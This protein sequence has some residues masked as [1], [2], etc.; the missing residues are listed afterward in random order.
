MPNK[1]NKQKKATTTSKK[2]QPTPG[3]KKQVVGKSNVL[4]AEARKYAKLINDP[5]YGPI[6]AP[7]YQSSGSGQFVRIESDFIL[8]AEATSVGAACI[9]TPG[10]V[11]VNGDGLIKPNAVVASD[12]AAITWAQ[13]T[14]A[15]CGTTFALTAGAVRAVSACLQVSFV[16]SELSRAGVVSLAQMSRQVAVTYTSLAKLRGGADRVVRMPDGVLEL[17][18]S[19]QAKNADFQTTGTAN[20]DV[21]E[22]PCLVMSTSG[23]PASTGVRVRLVQVLEWLPLSGT[24]IVNGTIA[25]ASN[26]SLQQVLAAM[27]KSNPQWQYELL[28]GLG[29]YAAKTIAWL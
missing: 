5:C 4:D 22:L 7:I 10:L 14:L 21:S 1:Q 24:G 8:G 27:Y 6:T 11:T 18:L 25:T 16:G 20:L 12:S 3:R 26:S 19:P 29:A 23:I 15:Q 13:D 28:T 9:F 2:G 17:K